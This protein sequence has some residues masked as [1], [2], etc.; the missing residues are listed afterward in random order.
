LYLYHQIKGAK[1]VIRYRNT[2]KILSQNKSQNIKYLLVNDIRNNPSWTKTYAI[3]V[4]TN[5]QLKYYLYCR[6][7]INRKSKYKYI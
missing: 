4:R 7:L 5:L 6:L 3:K 1:K 2:A